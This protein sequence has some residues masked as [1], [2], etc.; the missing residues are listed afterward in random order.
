MFTVHTHVPPLPS[1][2]NWYRQKL[3]SKSC[4]DNTCNSTVLTDKLTPI[5]VNLAWWCN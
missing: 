4:D 5:A 1:T 2:I 3:G